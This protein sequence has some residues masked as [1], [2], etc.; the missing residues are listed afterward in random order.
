MYVYTC[1][2][3]LYIYIQGLVQFSLGFNVVYC[4]LVQFKV[5][6]TLVQFRVQYTLVQFRV[7]YTLA[8]GCA[9]PAWRTAKTFIFFFYTYFYHS[10]LYLYR[11]L[12]ISKKKTEIWEIVYLYLSIYTL[13][14]KLNSSIKKENR[15]MGNCLS[16]FIDI[17]T[18][19]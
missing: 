3:M 12:S 11:F 10:F 4:S 5:Q 2:Y 1:T 15:K 9:H 17:Y 6:Y 19:P 18:K 16:I 13:S 14:P 7:Q 8:C